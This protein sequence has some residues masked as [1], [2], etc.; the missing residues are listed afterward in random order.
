MD[1]RGA[2]GRWL[3]ARQS[4]RPGLSRL[5][6]LGGAA[7]RASRRCSAC[8]R[9][10]TH[11]PRAERTLRDLPLEP[12]LRSEGPRHLGKAADAPFVADSLPTSPEPNEHC[13]TCR[14]N[15]D[16]EAK[17]RADDHLSL[18]AGASRSQRRELVD[19]SVARL[20][21]LAQLPLPIS[22]RPRRG[23][24]EG[25]TKIREQARVQYEG[26]ASG[27]PVYELLPSELERGLA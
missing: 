1:A 2:A 25:L 12:R 19:H 21:A 5:L 11:L 14:W 15:R 22:W 7:P 17:R 23:S 9:F 6:P 24:I 4:S 20:E 26:R 27:K 13:E 3:R 10:S 8:R 18:V 16:C